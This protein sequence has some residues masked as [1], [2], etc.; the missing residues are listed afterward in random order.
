[1]RKNSIIQY[2]NINERKSPHSSVEYF[3][4]SNKDCKEPNQ[5]TIHQGIKKYIKEKGQ[6]I[7]D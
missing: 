6:S 2:L 3:S 4:K 1:M 7:W 5:Y